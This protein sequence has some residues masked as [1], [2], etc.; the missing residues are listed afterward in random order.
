MND[1]IEQMMGE[2]NAPNKGSILA[3]FEG[4]CEEE[5]LAASTLVCPEDP[6]PWSSGQSAPKSK[7]SKLRT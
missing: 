3:D 4:D 1:D 2:R 7:K 5:P 6:W